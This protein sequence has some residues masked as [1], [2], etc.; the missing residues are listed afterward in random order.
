MAERRSKIDKSNSSAKDSRSFETIKV[1]VEGA[2]GRLLLNRPERL[3]AISTT[4]LQEI[5]EAARW[6]DS[7]RELRVVILS[8]AG[9]AFCAGA[10]LQNSPAAAAMPEARHS[11]IYR[12]EAGQYGLRAADALEQM[13]AVT[14][15]Q[16]HGYAV[17]GG[18]VFI[19]ACDLRVAADDASFF[20]PEIDLGIPLTWGA[21]PRLVRDIGPALTKELVMTCRRF[22]PAEA[23]AIGFIN[24]VVPAADLEREVNQL[25]AE[26]I[27]KPSVPIVITKEH[28]NAV[29]R[30]I[31]ATAFADGDSLIAAL[32]DEESRAVGATYMARTISRRSSTE[33]SKS[34]R[35][36]PPR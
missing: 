33:A 18:V 11:W 23:K 12:R 10:D 29:A 31:G 19:S 13:R 6:F 35:R 20:I 24:R 7:H 1:E 3:N 5:V 28:V 17:G 2:L 8:G 32:G 15:A 22:A 26:L 25:A 16:V 27:A 14:I 30:T 21:I 36:S 4:M 34:S 9:R